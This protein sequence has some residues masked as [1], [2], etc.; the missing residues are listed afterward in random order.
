MMALGMPTSDHGSD[1]DFLGE[2][3]RAAWRDALEDLAY[4]GRTQAGA[5][6][7]PAIPRLFARMLERALATTAGSERAMLIEYHTRTLQRMRA[8]VVAS[9]DEPQRSLLHTPLALD[10]VPR[11]AAALEAFFALVTAASVDPRVAF[12]AASATELLTLRPTVAALFAGAH[13][14]SYGPPLYLGPNDL[15]ALKRELAADRVH[16]VIDRRL[17]G[18]LIH[19]LSH[20]GCARA[21]LASPYLDE[22]ISAYLG[23]LAYPALAVPEPS[24]DAAMYG[25][26][27]FTQV[28]AHL[29]HIVGRDALIRAHAGVVPWD[30]VLPAG[31]RPILERLAW[32]QWLTG[33]QLSFLGQTDQ[34]VPWIKAF[35]LAAAGALPDDVTLAGL[36]AWPWSKLPRGAWTEADDALLAW[37]RDALATEPAL[38][39]E[40]A[41]RVVARPV[42]TTIDDGRIRRAATTYPLEHTPLHV[43][44]PPGAPDT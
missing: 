1:D 36:S 41:W 15:A 6:A 33:R 37:C 35:W 44:A 5:A 17:T 31:L 43:V 2:E 39:P 11:L 42:A 40:G 4:D 9:S 26:A 30:E 29:A 28:G 10:Q 21:P 14:G 27:W 16:R 18:P 25:A 22:C 24:E 32:E 3:L 7:P 23:A 12:G 20:F 8:E 34:P 19:E 38:T 13:Y